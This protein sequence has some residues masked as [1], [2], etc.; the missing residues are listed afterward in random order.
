M[1]TSPEE[2]EADIQA[3]W[4]QAV[5]DGNV[6]FMGSVNKVARFINPKKMNVLAAKK[7]ITEEYSKEYWGANEKVSNKKSGKITYL[8]EALKAM[9]FGIAE[10]NSIPYQVL[11]QLQ[12]K[13]GS[14]LIIH[15]LG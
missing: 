2:F 15:H 5:A 11:E 13:Y 6:E 8:D 9:V 3:I 4:D 7:W 1:D 10:E 12:E 14:K